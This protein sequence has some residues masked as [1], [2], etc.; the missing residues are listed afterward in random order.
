MATTETF[1][2]FGNEACMGRGWEFMYQKAMQKYWLLRRHFCIQLH[3][4]RKQAASHSVSYTNTGSTNCLERRN[5]MLYSGMCT[6]SLTALWLQSS[7]TLKPMNSP[8]DKGLKA[9]PYIKVKCSVGISLSLAF[10]KTYKTRRTKPMLPPLGI[11]GREWGHSSHIQG[12]LWKMHLQNAYVFVYTNFK[13]AYKSVTLSCLR[14]N[15]RTFYC[16]CLYGTA[17]CHSA[18]MEHVSLSSLNLP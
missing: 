13:Y 6:N 14:I 12:Q 11:S 15:F 18:E 4:Y 2:L 10:R 8:N 1:F 3:T 5:R 9:W 17:V 16:W 7:K